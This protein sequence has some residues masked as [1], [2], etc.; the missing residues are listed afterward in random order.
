L[1]TN[2]TKTNEQCS[3]FVRKIPK[4]IKA[5]DLDEKFSCFD[6]SGSKR[7]VKSLKISLDEDHSSRGY[8]FITYDCPEDAQMAIQMLQESESR[9]DCVAVHYKPKD[10]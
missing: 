1:G 7:P 4:D 10:R 9:A 6:P 8:G 5:S 3:I 2:L